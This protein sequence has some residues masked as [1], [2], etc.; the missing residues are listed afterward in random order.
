[1]PRTDACADLKCCT[2]PAAIGSRFDI[3][4]EIFSGSFISRM[5]PR[6]SYAHRPI[7]PDASC[8][9]YPSLR[10]ALSPQTARVSL[11]QTLL[12]IGHGSALQGFYGLCVLSHYL[13]LFPQLAD[14]YVCSAGTALFSDGYANGVIGNG[15]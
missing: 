3:R 7:K 9:L 4:R 14:F 11:P 2:T 1:M 13:L 5:V 15:T 10:R 12:I 6:H 8:N